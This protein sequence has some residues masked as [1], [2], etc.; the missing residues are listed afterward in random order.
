[1]FVEEVEFY[2]WKYPSRSFSGTPCCVRGC[3]FLPRILLIIEA[4]ND[5]CDERLTHLLGRDKFVSP[6]EE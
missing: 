5:R 4:N 6:L 2:V 3:W 1:M